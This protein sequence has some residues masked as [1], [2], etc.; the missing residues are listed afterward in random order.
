MI[1]GW[2]ESCLL[3]ALSP[4]IPR[5]DWGTKKHRVL[6]FQIPQL[7][8]IG[9]SISFEV[10]ANTF[11]FTAIASYFYQG[12]WFAA[13]VDGPPVPPGTPAKTHVS[14]IKAARARKTKFDLRHSFDLSR[15]VVILI[16]SFIRLANCVPL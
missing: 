7:F 3:A 16:E 8:R 2:G 6:F 12:L 15:S 10:M 11:I 13:I 9:G 5:C 14:S 1:L 4:G